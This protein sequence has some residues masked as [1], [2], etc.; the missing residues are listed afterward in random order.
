MGWSRERI[1]LASVLGVGVLALVV[2]R[3]LLQSSVSGPRESMGEDLLL[4][5][6]GESGIDA[7]VAV[8]GGAPGAQDS[9]GGGTEPT[10]LAT[11]AQQVESARSL[12]EGLDQRNAFAVSESWARELGVVS[13]GG[14]GD[15]VERGGPAVGE[16]VRLTVVQTVGG[17]PS[18]A[19]VEPIGDGFGAPVRIGESFWVDG[20]NG[21]SR[22]RTSRT[23]GTPPDDAT[24]FELVGLSPRSAWFRGGRGDRERLDIP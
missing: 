19:I 20:A 10:D 12:A 16:V 22:V 11:L 24:V 6:V 3:A 8:E 14:A 9:P 1:V 21:V 4:P 17:E 2:D 15:G 23:G 7:G 5:G 13:I 18:V